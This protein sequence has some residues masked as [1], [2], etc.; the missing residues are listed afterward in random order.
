MAKTTKKNFSLLIKPASA[1]CNLRCTYCF[2]LD[3]LDFYPQTRVHR[4][5]EEVLEKVISSYLHTNQQN[6]TFGWQGGEP[7]L[8]GLDFFRKVVFL[9]QKYGRPGAYVSN[10]LQT[11]GT[12]ITEDLAKHFCHYKFLLG[13]S[14][15][16]PENI[17]NKYRTYESG[18]GS[19]AKIMENINLLQKHKVEFNIL[20]L[21]SKSNVHHARTIYR[22]FKSHGFYYHQYIPC[23]EFDDKGNHLSFSITAQ[24]W[25]NFLTEIFDE[26]QANDAY[27]ISVRNFDTIV[28]YLVRN[29]YIVCHMD[30]NCRLYFLL[31]YNGDVYP[32]DFFVDRDLKLG[33]IMND[34]WNSLLSS[35]VYRNFG[36]MKT[37]WCPECSQCAYL[38]YC[39]GDCLKHRIYAGN[40]PQNKSFLC[41]GL[42][43]FYKN[44]LPRFKELAEE[45]KNRESGH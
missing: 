20:T 26:W 4:M 9:Q 11:N 12:L 45:I 2:Y 43:Y 1:D 42:K 15:D 25:G 8:M 3:H 16:G 31:E 10:G 36:G 18:K 17:H 5:Q 40:T 35:K 21:V 22:F 7:T 32:C 23:V 13:V 27:K 28:N 29:N 14:L 44:S 24:E 19:F 39:S 6:Y 41:E 30:R 37:K 34:N 38:S 33:N